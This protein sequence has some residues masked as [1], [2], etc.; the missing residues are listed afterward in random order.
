MPVPEP[1]P[2]MSILEFWPQPAAS[3]S[4]KAI[5]DG[6]ARKKKMW[7]GGGRKEKLQAEEGDKEKW[8]FLQFAE[9]WTPNERSEELRDEML[10]TH[11]RLYSFLFIL[12]PW[13]YDFTIYYFK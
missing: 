8:D 11:V 2:R 4:L 13:N 7:C 6:E 10:F 3:M 12:I 9:A 5:K 1:S